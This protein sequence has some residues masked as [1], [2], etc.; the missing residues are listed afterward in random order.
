MGRNS[1]LGG[2]TV[3][4]PGSSW[5]SK[6]KKKRAKKRPGTEA[7][8]RRVLILKEAARQAKAEEKH[9]YEVYK[10]LKQRRKADERMRLTEVERRRIWILEEAARQAKAASKQK[11]EE[12]VRR[13]RERKA[14]ER[15]KQEEMIRLHQERKSA[16]KR[17]RKLLHEARAEAARLS[18][19]LNPKGRRP[20][21]PNPVVVL[22]KGGRTVRRGHLAH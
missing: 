2:S 6:P 19:K 5:F 11:H 15:R 18:K 12:M 9:K 10:R 7:E 1:Y 17:A 16:E 20:A 22:I 21:Q 14:A 4:G 3:I 8:R 13:Q